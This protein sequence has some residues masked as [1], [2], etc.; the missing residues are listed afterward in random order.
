MRLSLK[1]L[2]IA[3]VIASTFLLSECGAPPPDLAPAAVGTFQHESYR[4]DLIHREEMI[5]QG[6]AL[7]AHKQKLEV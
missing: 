7:H 4:S 5:E 3:A 2:L 6:R 1:P